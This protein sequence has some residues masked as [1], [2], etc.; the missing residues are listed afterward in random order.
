MK[1]MILVVSSDPV[2]CKSTIDCLSDTYDL[3]LAN[4]GDEGI[5]RI[6]ENLLTIQMVILD[7]TLID[8]KPQDWMKSVKK[9]HLPY[10]LL[11]ADD[12]L[13]EWMI[14][15]MKEGV[16]DIMR[17][18]PFSSE[19]LI[20]AVQ[21]GFEYLQV[22]HYLNRVMHYSQDQTIKHRLTK[23]LNLLQTRKSEGID[24]SSQ[25][26]ATYFPCSDRPQ[27]LPLNDILQA[28]I[29]GQTYD[30]IKKWK[31]RPRLLIVEDEFETRDA[32]HFQ[33]GRDFEILLASSSEDAQ[34]FLTD[35]NEIDAALLDVGLPKM[36]GDDL[37]GILKKTYPNI[38][39]IMLTGFDEHRLITKTINNG[40]GDYIIKPYVPHILEHKLMTLLQSSLINR[41]L[42]GYMQAAG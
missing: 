5:D 13:T 3:I 11:I 36:S 29:S 1:N 41:A 33:F 16:V 20:L 12:R 32:L 39:I 9:F 19:E 2:I 25:E 40:A 10:T 21:Q 37:V 31:K 24:L 42:A 18:N 6:I 14:E 35:G 30:L 23:F 17:K 26:I 34:A 7:T 27:A 8:M 28:I 22:T 15:S 38:Q 4:T